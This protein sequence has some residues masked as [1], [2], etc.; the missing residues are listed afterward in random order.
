MEY[1]HCLW[2]GKLFKWDKTM[3][4]FCGDC[5]VKIE[6]VEEVVEKI[7]GMRVNLCK[8]LELRLGTS[9]ER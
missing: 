8:E 3:Y 9:R 4:R 5:I 7:T 2:C 6:D 1:K